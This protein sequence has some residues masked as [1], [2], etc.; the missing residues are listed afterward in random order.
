METTPFR[1]PTSSKEAGRF[2]RLV[3]VAAIPCLLS[4]VHRFGLRVLVMLAVA[5]VVGAAAEYGV[6]AL[7]RRRSPKSFITMGLLFVLILPPGLP[8]WMVAL[9]MAFAIL[10][11]KEVFGGTGCQV[12]SP[13]LLGRGFLMLSYPAVMTGAYV[14]PGEG[15][16]G[17]AGRYFGVSGTEGLIRTTPLVLVRQGEATPIAKLLWG[18][19]AGC[20]GETAALAILIGGTFLLVLRVIDWRIVVGTLG[21]FLLLEVLLGP[22]PGGASLPVGWHVLAGGGL[23]GT[24][25]LA[26]DP[27]TCPASAVGRLAFGVL[28]GASAMVLRRFATCPDDAGVAILLGN[29][30]VPFLNLLGRHRREQ[31]GKDV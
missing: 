16:W 17:M 12:F 1:H 18:G 2:L 30:L 11:G 21:S 13:P 27:V 3:A 22:V 15:I 28:V 9:G 4:G 24:F 10:V 31:D 23:F 29:M 26:T 6:D 19:A 14:V 20:V 8:F 5:W 25:F 7:R